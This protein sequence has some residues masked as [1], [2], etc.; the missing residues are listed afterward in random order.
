[1]L[2]CHLLQL[3]L[4]TTDVFNIL[5]LNS[6]C[7]SSLRV[8]AL[9]WACLA[10][11]ELCPTAP[12]RTRPCRR[13]SWVSSTTPPRDGYLLRSSREATSKPQRPI[14]PS[15]STKAATLKRFILVFFVPAWNEEQNDKVNFL[16]TKILLF[17]V[18]NSQGCWYTRQLF[19]QSRWARPSS[20][21]NK[22]TNC[23]PLHL[24]V[25]WQQYQLF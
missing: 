17:N 15:V 21:C 13:S 9:W 12:P 11:L 7:V 23:A 5:W 16:F 4:Q 2:Q 10:A 25:S 6:L 1:M 19:W 24:N 20:A 14:N 18:T 8:V 22:K 3:W